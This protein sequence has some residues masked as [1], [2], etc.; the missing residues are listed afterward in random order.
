M[1]ITKDTTECKIEYEEQD[2]QIQDKLTKIIDNALSRDVPNA[3]MMKKQDKTNRLKY[4]DG[5]KHFFSKSELVFPT[6]LLNQVLNAISNYDLGID[7]KIKDVSMKPFV[8]ADEIPDEL[9]LAGKNGLHTLKLRDYQVTA[10]K[11][12]YKYNIGVINYAVASG[13]TAVGA[14]IIKQALPKLKQ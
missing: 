5:K 3:F 11:N 8:N 10:V 13:K 7:Y 1:I 14:E 4:W 9:Y 2:K 6:G 12:F